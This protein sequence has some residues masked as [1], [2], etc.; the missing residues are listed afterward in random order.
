MK[1]N[2]RNED[3]EF[4]LVNTAGVNQGLRFCDQDRQLIYLFDV[5]DMETMLI[6]LSLHQNYIVEISAD[7]EEYEVLARVDD[8]EEFPEFFGQTSSMSLDIDPFEYD[9]EDTGLCYI[10][11]RNTD[12]TKGGGGSVSNI[13]LEYTKKY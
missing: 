8:E 1:C 12:I 9:C 4:I 11:I 7:G 13:Y 5:A 3:V 2:N 10:R 6:R